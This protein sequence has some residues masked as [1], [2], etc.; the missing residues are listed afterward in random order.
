M[1]VHK[2]KVVPGLDDLPVPDSNNRN[3]TESDLRISRLKA[4]TIALMFSFH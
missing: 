4:E 3:T 1:H 2:I